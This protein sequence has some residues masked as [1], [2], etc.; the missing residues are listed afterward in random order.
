MYLSPSHPFQG[1][2]DLKKFTF[3]NLKF[4]SVPEGTELGRRDHPQLRSVI[5]GGEAVFCNWSDHCVGT[6]HVTVRIRI[7]LGHFVKPELRH[8]WTGPYLYQD[9]LIVGLLAP[10]PTLHLLQPKSHG[11]TPQRQIWG[12]RTPL[13][14]LFPD[15]AILT[16]SLCFSVLQI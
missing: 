10:F 11:N 1:C 2:E 9:C 8:R 3:L 12:D 4:S 15:V 13:F 5:H 6:P 7:S 14:D 16:K